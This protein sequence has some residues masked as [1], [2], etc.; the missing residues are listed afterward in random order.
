VLN[1]REHW[2]TRFTEWEMRTVEDAQAIVDAAAGELATAGVE[3]T[4][5]VGRA[6]TGRTARQI[7]DVADE[8][9]AQLIVMGSGGLSELQGL[10]L[11]SVTHRV[12]QLSPRPILVVP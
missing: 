8:V 11:G 10:V 5:R 9:D 4:T 12:L 6:L 7:C 3:T 2:V 1:V